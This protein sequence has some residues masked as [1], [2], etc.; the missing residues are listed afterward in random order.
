MSIEDVEELFDQVTKGDPVA[1]IYEPLLVAKDG[2]ELFVEVH[3]DPY[4]R[5]GVTRTALAQAL[6]LVGEE[7]AADDPVIAEVLKLREG[8]AV[9]LKERAERPMARR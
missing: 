1:I 9:S 2:R 7:D 6:A 3:R 5:G 8:R 4:G